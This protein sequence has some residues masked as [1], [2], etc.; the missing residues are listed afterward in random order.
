M[1]FQVTNLSKNYPSKWV[2][3]DVSLD[4]GPGEILGVFGASGSGKS[5]LIRAIAGLDKTNGGTLRYRDKDLTDLSFKDRGIQLP[6]IEPN[7]SGWGL[8]KKNETQDTAGSEFRIRAVEDALQKADG[9]LLLDDPFCG[10][11]EATRSRLHENL[12]R[13]AR[14]KGLIVILATSDYDEICAVCDRVAVLAGTY[15]RQTGTPQEVY[16]RPATA[17][18]AAIVG[19]NNLFPA[20]RLTSNKA[21]LPEFLT[22]QGDHRLFAQRAEKRALGAINQDVTLAVRPEHI[23]MSFGASFPEDNLL[24]A[25]ITGVKYFGA[26]T[27]VELDCTGLKLEAMVLRLVGLN[28]GDE[29]MVGLP[30]DRIAILK[31]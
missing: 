18:I 17:A 7:S 20:R 5:T 15:I 16:E 29:C 14:E 3:R 30:P 24:K 21:E 9:V 26:M 22:L 19:R 31:D 2:L 8:F 4:V 27:I 13:A 28:V 1:S 25:V 10:T 11:D 12:R 6:Q 23:S